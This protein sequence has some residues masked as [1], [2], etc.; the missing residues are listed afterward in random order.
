MGHMSKLMATAAL[1]STVAC[2]KCGSGTIGG[3]YGVVDPMPPPARCYGGGVVAT[4]RWVP[5]PG[6]G[7]LLEIDISATGVSTGF[8]Y[9]A[10]KVQG[11][12]LVDEPEPFDLGSLSRAGTF[13]I[14]DASTADAGSRD[15]GA[16]RD[17]G[18]IAV[19]S[20]DG[21]STDAA[22][23]AGPTASAIGPTTKTWRIDPTAATVYLF[24]DVT[25]FAGPGTLTVSA[26]YGKTADG[27]DELKTN[28][29]EN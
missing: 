6:G 4:A 19:T 29:A 16:L 5:K 8:V 24:F 1:A 27:G 12:T 21:G 3:G 28:V 11:G 20:G 25:C 13:A 7:R 14:S 18:P 23:D 10:V 22:V 9:S 2:S 17:A 15:A 26:S